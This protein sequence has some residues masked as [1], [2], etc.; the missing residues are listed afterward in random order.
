[1]K[2]ITAVQIFMFTFVSYCVLVVDD[3]PERFERGSQIFQQW[4]AVPVAQAGII[5][6]EMKFEARKSMRRVKSSLEPT[7]LEGHIKAIRKYV[8]NNM[9]SHRF[10][11]KSQL[12]VTTNG[13]TDQ[14]E[15]FGSD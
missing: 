15:K 12:P 5:A 10:F 6:G 7:N 8:K 3:S 1:M 13:A 2:A 9:I 4:A 11:A 14:T